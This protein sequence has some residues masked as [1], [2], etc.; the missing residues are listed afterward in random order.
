MQNKAYKKI[1]ISLLLHLGIGTFIFVVLLFTRFGIDYY[2]A[3]AF[4]VTGILLL[5]YA[6]IK[7]VASEGAFNVLGFWFQKFR[8][9][10]KRGPKTNMKYY[11]YVEMK[12]E[13]EKPILWPSLAVGGLFFLIGLVISIIVT[14]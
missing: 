5:G 12:R 3:D 2:I 4:S 8:D 1:I 7:F 6:A 14:L 10:F 11:D 9:M 13:N